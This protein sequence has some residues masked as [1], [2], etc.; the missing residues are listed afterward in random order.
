MAKSIKP[1]YQ[2]PP[3]SNQILR[4]RQKQRLADLLQKQTDE[5]LTLL[6][7]HQQQQQEL[8]RRYR[9]LS[10]DD[11]DGQAIDLLHDQQPTPPCTPRRA[12]NISSNSFAAS[13]DPARTHP[14]STQ[15]KY[16]DLTSDD[17]DVPLTSTHNKYALARTAFPHPTNSDLGL[18]K[19][20]NSALSKRTPPKNGTLDSPPVNEFSSSNSKTNP[21]RPSEKQKREGSFVS[22]AGRN[23]SYVPGLSDLNP[24]ARELPSAEQGKQ[25]PP[26]AFCKPKSL[27]KAVER[28][29]TL[30]RCIPP[31]SIPAVAPKIP[32]TAKNKPLKG[33]FK[34]P[35]L[36]ATPR[37]ES[38]YLGISQTRSTREESILSHVSTTSAFSQ[39]SSIGRKRKEREVNL[40]DGE[41][42]YRPSPTSSPTP[43]PRWQRAD[44]QKPKP[45]VKR[46]KEV[47]KYGFL[48]TVGQT[49]ETPPS[50]TASSATPFIPYIPGRKSQ[51]PENPKAH[52]PSASI[53]AESARPSTA[54]IPR[55]NTQPS[56]ASHRSKRKERENANKR[57]KIFIHEQARYENTPEIERMKLHEEERGAGLRASTLEPTSK[58]LMAK[59]WKL[60]GTGVRFGS[61]SLFDHGPS[62]LRATSTDTSY[63]AQ[64]WMSEKLSGDRYLA[65]ERESGMENEGSEYDESEADKRRGELAKEI[66]MGM[67]ED[68]EY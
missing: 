67:N 42:D 54:S 6:G 58:A 26:S 43:E 36:P 12:S 30:D 50:K 53:R 40:S 64:D 25:T 34:I 51:Y 60:P 10:I 66:E 16:I 32:Q 27:P 59:G 22:G 48:E 1:K 38:G 17:E 3:D 20:P 63:T 33:G 18:A 28:A 11:R 61:K 68:S 21:L 37:S 49:P 8:L 56:A 47:N 29:D 23:K 62:A 5:H 39:R 46:T 65:K 41:Q 7:K 45:P 52:P 57:I 9:E 2:N 24:S 15:I 55:S 14:Q 4:K 19:G 44:F 35:S 31:P 13:E